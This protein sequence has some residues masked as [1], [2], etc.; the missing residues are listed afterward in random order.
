MTNIQFQTGAVDAG[1]CV[2]NA[3]EQIKM[4]YG[5]YLGVA[6][7]AMVLTGC[8]PCFNLFLVGPIMGGVY[9]FVLRDMRREPVDFGMMFKGFEKFVPLMVIGLIQAVPGI[10]V[11]CLQF[12][13]R[14]GELGLGSGSK[15]GD[16]DFFQSSG[17]ELPIAQGL[18][19]V[20]GLVIVVIAIFAMVWALMFSFAIPLAMEHDLGPVDALRLS[21]RAAM[22]N[23]GG[24]ILLVIFEALVG[25]IGLLLCGIGLILISTPIMYVA[26]VFA[27]RQ[28]FPMAVRSELNFT[29]PPPSAYGNFGTGI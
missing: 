6:V 18:L 8:I 10:I 7:V 16:Y 14:L 26:N 25:L 2:S 20:L 4:N 24:L 13:V 27:Y 21:A 17:P 29:P 23:I 15:N 28:V 12:G 9:Y 5:L 22:A 19:I 11:Q 1:A 3:W